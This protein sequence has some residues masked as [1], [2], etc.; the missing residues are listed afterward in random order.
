[1]WN[2]WV[3]GACVICICAQYVHTCDVY[4]CIFACEVCVCAVF[5]CVQVCL[6]VV[7]RCM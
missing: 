7:Y 5:V 2:I 6:Y 3:Y 1:M 4:V